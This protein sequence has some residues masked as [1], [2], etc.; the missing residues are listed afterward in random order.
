M[1]FQRYQSAIYPDGRAAPSLASVNPERNQFTHP[2]QCTLSPFPFP[3]LKP[4][5]ERG[6]R[7]CNSFWQSL[8]D[9]CLVTQEQICRK[10]PCLRA[11]SVP[12]WSDHFPIFLIPLDIS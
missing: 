4:S 7:R 11:I 1:P 8:T 2:I 3:H 6:C 5:N 10:L 12:N 9:N